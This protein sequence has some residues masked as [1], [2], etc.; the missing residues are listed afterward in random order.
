MGW[1]ANLILLNPTVNPDGQIDPL[2][3]SALAEQ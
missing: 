1:D 2:W 3:G